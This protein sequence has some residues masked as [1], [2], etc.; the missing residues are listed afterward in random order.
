MPTIMQIS[1]KPVVPIFPFT[2]NVVD[3]LPES[4]N[5]AGVLH[6]TSA[7]TVNHNHSITTISSDTPTNGLTI[8]AGSRVVE[9]N[10]TLGAPA[11]QII[12]LYLSNTEDITYTMP[13]V[14]IKRN[15]GLAPEILHDP[16]DDATATTWTYYAFTTPVTS[17][18][19]RFRYLSTSTASRSFS[20][21]A[22]A[23]PF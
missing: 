14:F 8:P 7:A 16:F 15:S 21:V 4:G 23:N 10:Y 1:L 13:G 11:T 12:D 17:T 22:V 6:F 9:V 20:V 5:N 2:D 18:R 3:L 19:V